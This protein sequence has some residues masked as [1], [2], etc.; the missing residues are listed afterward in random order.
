MT[1][2]TTDDDLPELPP[3]APEPLFVIELGDNGGRFAPTSHPEVREWL[4][5]EMSLWNTIQAQH[6]GV[7]AAKI[8]RVEQALAALRDARGRIDD[9]ERSG[10][11][12]TNRNQNPL[13]RCKS[14]IEAAFVSH[15]LPHSSTPLYKRI[16]ALAVQ[17]SIAASFYASV[18]FSV[19]SGEGA[20]PPPTEVRG[21]R[22]Y[23]E[24]LIDRYELG[25]EALAKSVLA[26][27]E[28]FE[29]IRGKL[30]ALYSEKTSRLDGLDQRFLKTV[31]AIRNTRVAQSESFKL[32]Q[33]ERNR[34]FEKLKEKHAGDMAVMEEAFRVRMGLHAPVDYWKKK[35]AQHHR[36]VE[37][38]G[39]AVGGGMALGLFLLI[40]LAVSVLSDVPAGKPP[41]LWQV[42]VLSLTSLFTVW[43]M[44]I[45]VRMLLSNLHLR[46]DAEERAVM[47][48]TY[49]A[50][51]TGGQVTE[52]EGRE[53]ILTA[54]FRPAADGIVKDEGMPL[55]LLEFLTRSGK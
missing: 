20:R 8:Y 9:A 6:G 53:L 26:R 18:H 40:W 48:E 44:R 35:R 15:Q 29:A 30:E 19:V 4:D 45:L 10:Q 46:T 31:T 24:G 43:G 17:D 21:W 2:S 3:S 7:Q 42:A 25:G 27:Q 50:M 13:E 32:A 34:E 36:A 1:D 12:P 23:V 37:V 55:N 33:G 38:F 14:Q 47:V 52:K 41:A 39:Y 28:A 49:L 5:R 11:Q 16:N 54:L 51:I 22:G